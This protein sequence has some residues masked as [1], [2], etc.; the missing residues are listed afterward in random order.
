LKTPLKN[1]ERAPVAERQ[2]GSQ[3]EVG[4]EL[5]SRDKFVVALL[6]IVSMLAGCERGDPPPYLPTFGTETPIRASVPEYVFGVF[7]IQNAISIFAAYQPV[8]DAINREANGYA[9]RLETSR[10]FDAFGTKLRQHKFD[11]AVTNP[12]QTLAAEEMG[13]HIFAKP[14]C[15]EK[16][17]GIV[18]ARKDSGL[19]TVKDLRG[20]AVSFASPTAWATIMTKILLRKAG[21]NVETEAQPKYVGSLDSAVMN[22]YSGITAAGGTVFAHWQGMKARRPEIFE[23][24]E[25][26]W[27]APPVG[28]LAFMAV[29]SISEAHVTAI[30]RVLFDLGKS[31]EGRAILFRIDCP[32]V[33]PAN[34]RTFDPVRH[35][36]AEYKRFFGKLPEMEGAK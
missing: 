9:V 2:K 18:F 17:R 5:G 1:T 11:L 3:L 7:P 34:G 20:K 6:M 24:L 19:K 27:I 33:E 15:D 31:E 21:L 30:A 29:N 23:A 36:V 10:D 16:F 4:M 8:I 35:A 14:G 25:I 13:Y 32:I 12:L 28:N 26:K 22:V